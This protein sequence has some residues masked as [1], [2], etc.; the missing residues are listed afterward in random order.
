M[1]WFRRKNEPEEDYIPP[2]GIGGYIPDIH[3]ELLVPIRRG[4]QSNAAL[5]RL[6]KWT[7]REINARLAREGLS[8]KSDNRYDEPVATYPLLEQVKEH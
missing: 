7:E 3:P 6:M 1:S 2:Y 8:G 4:G 5:I